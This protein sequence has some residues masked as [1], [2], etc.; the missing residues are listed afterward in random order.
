MSYNY[1]CYGQIENDKGEV[2]EFSK[3]PLS[4]DLK[5]YIDFEDV[6]NIFIPVG[7]DENDADDKKRVA[8]HFMEEFKECGSYNSSYVVNLKDF[9]DY[10]AAK[11]ATVHAKI[12]GIFKAMGID[13]GETD[14]CNEDCIYD[15]YELNE[16]ANNKRCI[17]VSKGSIIE[18]V[19]CIQ[20]LDKYH[21]LLDMAAVFTS[22]AYDYK[23]Y[24]NEKKSLLIVMM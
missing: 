11:C 15:L 23:D 21:Y 19:R 17:P 9:I 12:S 5:W 16:N 2:V 13:M 18:L 14:I 22:M 24:D 1:Y 20:E 3:Q 6:P 4:D 10:Y 8:K 7:F